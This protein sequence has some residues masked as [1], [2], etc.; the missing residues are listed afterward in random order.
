MENVLHKVKAQLYLNWLTDD[1]NDYSARVIS[2]RSLS[3]VDIC[4]T[5]VTRGGA[6]RSVDDMESI[7]NVFFKEMAYQLC[8]GFSVNTGFFTATP[9]LRGVFNDPKET[10][11]P[12]KHSLLFQ[13]NQGEQLRKELANVSIVITGVG[14]SSIAIERVLD[15]KTGSVNDL[16]TPNRNLRI[17][18][19]KL[20]LAGEHPDVGV[21]FVNTATSARTKVAPDEIVDNNPSELV[22]FTPDLAAGTYSL[23][24]ISQYSGSV[25]L[26][27]PRTAV[28]DKP[29]TV[30]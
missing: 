14:E 2:E 6:T 30:Q 19:Y 7:V 12:E 9:L 13:F 25:L 1:P 11:N 29:L 16:I 27:E 5:A 21:Y 10:F 24:V 15:V 3:I 4:R 18:G 17:K 23:E 28:F 20:K 8:D 22:V 26:K